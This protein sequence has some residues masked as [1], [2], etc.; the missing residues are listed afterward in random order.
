EG[1][2]L[3]IPVAREESLSFHSQAELDAHIAQLER[4]MREAAENLDF[5]RAAGLR[6][7][8]KTLKSRELGLTASRSFR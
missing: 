8:I 1:D 5:E 2:Y 6:D 3:S 4:E 7:R